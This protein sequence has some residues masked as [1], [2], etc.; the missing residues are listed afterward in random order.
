[1][2]KKLKIIGI[3]FFVI[4]IILSNYY[5]YADSFGIDNLQKN[6][7]GAN[8][9]QVVREEAIGEINNI[10]ND[11]IKII[12]TIGTVISVIVLIVIGIKYMIGSVDEKAQ[13]KKSLL[14]YL[15]GAFVLFGS[16]QLLKMIYYLANNIF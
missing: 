4:C 15:V 12:S 5:V 1:M 10:A 14:P 2:K 3:V 9:E 16:S 13:Y 6:E 8:G 11:I 7:K